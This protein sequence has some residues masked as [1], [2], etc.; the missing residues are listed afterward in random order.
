MKAVNIFMSLILTISP[1]ARAADGASGEAGAKPEAKTEK[2]AEKKNGGKVRYRKVQEVSFDDEEL[3]GI[4][5]NP[6]GSY[7]TDKKTMKFLPL[8]EVKE[9]ME[10]RL[11]ESLEYLK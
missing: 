11:L 9:K 3:D 4:V 1:P 5:R 10:Q 2:P 6:M 8:Y 7:V